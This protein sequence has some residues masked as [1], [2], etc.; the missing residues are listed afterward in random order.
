MISAIN[1]IAPLDPSEIKT[2]NRCLQGYARPAP[3]NCNWLLH[4][5]YLI[6]NAIK[7]LFFCSDWQKAEVILSH[8]LQTYDAI[9]NTLALIAK[10]Y[11]DTISHESGQVAIEEVVDELKQH[12]LTFHPKPPVLSEYDAKSTDADLNEGFVNIECYHRQEVFKA[13]VQS[14]PVPDHKLKDAL[15]ESDKL[16][17]KARQVLIELARK[18]RGDVSSVAAP[19]TPCKSESNSYLP[20]TIATVNAA[21]AAGSLIANRIQSRKA[22]IQEGLKIGERHTTQ[23]MVKHFDL[24]DCFLRVLIIGQNYLVNPGRLQEWPTLVRIRADMPKDESS[25][26]CIVS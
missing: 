3:G 8:K 12:A 10:I 14:L 16:A 19:M 15:R 7:F 6:W 22:A 11:H 1:Q 2:L 18:N 23:N 20:N 25:E 9:N 17:S 26:N 4:Q 13:Y 21:V 5:I 24:I